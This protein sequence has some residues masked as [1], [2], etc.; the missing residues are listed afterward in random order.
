ML[1][2]AIGEGIGA[3]VSVSRSEEQAKEARPWAVHRLPSVWFGLPLLEGDRGGN[4]AVDRGLTP[5]PAH[6]WK[7]EAD[8]RGQGGTQQRIQK[9]ICTA[10]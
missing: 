4:A 2:R 6:P 9:L 10:R 8:E 7:E 3:F 5:R 1:V